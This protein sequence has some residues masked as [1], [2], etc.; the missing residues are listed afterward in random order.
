MGVIFDIQKM[1]VHDGPGLRTTVFLKGCPLRCKWCHNPEGLSNKIQLSFLEDKCIFCRK[2]ANVC[3]HGVHS[4]INKTHKVD[5]AKCNLCGNCISEC[6]ANALDFCGKECSPKEVIDIVSKDDCFFGN[7]GGVTF[8]GGEAMQQVDFLLGLLQESKKRNY[9]TCIDTSGYAAWRDFEKVLPYTDCFLYDIK[10]FSSQVH[11]K[12]T[13]VD[14]D[15]I[16]NNLYKLSNCNKDIFIRTPL[17]NEYNAFESEIQKIA[18]MLC[19][20]HI[21]G[22]TLM[23]YHVLG[24]T[25]RAMIGMNQ[26]ELLT[27]PNNQKMQKFKQIFKDNNVRII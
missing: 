11:V 3:K 8:S 12:S 4:F 22:I 13:G 27:A 17:I 21:K 6:P 16:L 24:R 1:S 15:L 14:N 20:L 26:S 23:P 5:F 18:V 19:D 25:K 9:H 7:D 10:A 2:C